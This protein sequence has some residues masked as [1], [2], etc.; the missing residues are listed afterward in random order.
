M[1]KILSLT[2]AAGAMLTSASLTAEARDLTLVGWGGASQEVHRNVYFKPYAEKSGNAFVE[3]SYNGGL[4]KIKAMVDTKSVTWD[5]ILVEDPDLIRGC[6]D[7]LFETIQWAKIGEKANYIDAAVSDCGVGSYVWSI[8][9]AYDG[10]A[11][12]MGPKNWADFWD[13]KKFPG[14]RG[15]RKGAK[16]NLEI[17]LMADGVAPKDVYE[18]LA[19][20]E[21]QV[22]AFAKLDELKAHIQW[23]EAG[24]Q[25]PEWLA[26]GDVVMTTAYNGRVTNA[27]K[28]GKNFKISWDG[29]IYAVDSW[30]IIKGSSNKD[31]AMEFVGFASAKD[32]QV[33]FPK[34]IPYGV[35]NK[36]AIEAIPANLSADLPTDKANLKNALAN[37][38]EFWIDFEEELNERFNSWAAK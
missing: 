3:D 32:N 8:A 1:K 23:W 31:K 6:E 22:R 24:A 35:T 12:K 36:S 17:A 4:A 26:S 2:I 19:S 29:Q 37:D 20:E 5:A 30:A 34:G 7:G 13:V 18:V 14:K 15:L 16:F 38:T 11:L 9:L 10:D 21:G 28:E 27:N 33:K 25:P